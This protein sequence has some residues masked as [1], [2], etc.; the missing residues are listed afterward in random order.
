MSWGSK[1]SGGV[2][3]DI[4]NRPRGQIVLVVRSANPTISSTKRFSSVTR[5]SN[6]CLHPIGT[7]G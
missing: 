2:V 1:S 7:A 5:S 3:L 6:A 4:Q